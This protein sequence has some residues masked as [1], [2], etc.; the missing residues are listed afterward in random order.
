MKTDVVIFLRTPEHE[1]LHQGK[2]SA[3]TVTVF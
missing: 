3:M 1:M 2:V